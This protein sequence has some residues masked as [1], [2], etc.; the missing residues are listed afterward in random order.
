MSKT[1]R[2]YE[3]RPG[4]ERSTPVEIIAGEYERIREIEDGPPPARRIL[5]YARDE[6]NPLHGEFTWDDSIAGEQWRIQE[7]HELANCYFTIESE[8]DGKEVKLIGNYSITVE[9]G[10]RGYEDPFKVWRDPS[11][12][13]DQL[14][15]LRRALV[16]AVDRYKNFDKCK[17][18][19]NA[20]RRIIAKYME[21][22][23][24]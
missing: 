5:D 13:E 11:F 19:V 18:S 17:P 24:Q 6:D 14:D 16:A 3:Y 2:R 4:R 8:P 7:A 23:P 22:V 21:P 9:G 20:I 12:Q 15:N 10:E 1:K